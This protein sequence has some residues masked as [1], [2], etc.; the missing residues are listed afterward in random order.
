M[1]QQCL[2]CEENQERE[3]LYSNWIFTVSALQIHFFGLQTPIQTV[4]FLLLKMLEIEALFL[5]IELNVKICE[6]YYFD[7][8]FVHE[9]EKESLSSS[10]AVIRQVP[11][12][13][14]ESVSGILTE[15]EYAEQNL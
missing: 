12:G 14:C 3:S 6:N 15:L 13:S 7:F 1:H 11:R 5:P 2:C 4:S 9:N 10:S 8:N